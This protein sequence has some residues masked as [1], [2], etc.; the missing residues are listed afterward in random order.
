[1]SRSSLAINHH[2][3]SI[4]LSGLSMSSYTLAVSFTVLS[5]LPSVIVNAL[6]MA[7][8]VVCS[9]YVTAIN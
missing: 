2:P 7:I 5:P 3:F 4:S 1:M 6:A 8:L 9:I